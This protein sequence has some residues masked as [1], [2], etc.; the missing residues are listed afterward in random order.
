M[1]VISDERK[2][3]NHR[4]P[5][6][7]LRNLLQTILSSREEDK[8]EEMDKL[9]ALTP[10]LPEIIDAVA[11]N[12][13]A[14]KHP[15]YEQAVQKTLSSVE[16]TLSSRFYKMVNIE[17]DEPIKILKRYVGFVNQ[18]LRFDLLNLYKRKPIP[19]SLNLSFETDE[20]GSAST[21]LDEITDADRPGSTSDRSLSLLDLHIEQENRDQIKIWRRYIERDPEGGL[22]ENCI[23]KCAECNCQAIAIACFL[24]ESPFTIRA[25]AQ[26]VGVNEQTVYK[27]WKRNCEKILKLVWEN[28]EN[29]RYLLDTDKETG[30]GNSHD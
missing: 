17:E 15:D 16:K 8:K 12:G 27:H 1:T 14:K 13:T 21:S 4:L 6:E 20:N 3:A 30:E 18:R 19:Y 5:E 7:Y 11:W 25:F 29:Y 24:N 2:M 23:K 10:S 22:T 26:Q 9:L 28:I